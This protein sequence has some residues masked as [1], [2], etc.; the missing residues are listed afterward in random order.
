M[1]QDLKSVNKDVTV[2]NNLENSEFEAQGVEEIVDRTSMQLNKRMVIKAPTT[3]DDP[4][5]SGIQSFAAS[6]AE[7]STSNENVH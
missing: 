2:I 4:E 3:R 6:D 5:Q 1:A 7:I